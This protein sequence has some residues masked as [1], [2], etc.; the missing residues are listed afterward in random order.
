VPK[1]TLITIRVSHFCEKARW[2][3]ERAGVGF[4]EEAHPPLL[5]LLATVPRGGRSVP[6]LVTPHGTLKDSAAIVAHA[7]RKGPRER[8]LFPEDPKEC[9]EAEA[10]ARRFDDDLGPAVRRILYDEILGIPALEKQI[11]LLATNPLEGRLMAPFR[12]LLAKGMRR[13]MRIDAAGVAR[14]RAKLDAVLA[15]VEQ[16]LADGRR[17][18]VGKRFTVADLT[19]AALFAPAVYAPGYGCPLPALES[20]P[21]VLQETVAAFR[22]RP[23]GRFVMET[24]ARERGA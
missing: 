4:V 14:S 3:L 18:L 2:A 6:M 24:Y 22:A 20:L 17:Y 10:L 13:G 11:L 23:A 12:G 16:R 7:D 9:A 5:H 19:F 8:S 1:P 21:A 15:D